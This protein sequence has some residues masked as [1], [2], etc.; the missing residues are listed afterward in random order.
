MQERGFTR[1]ERF[2]LKYYIDLDWVERITNFLKP[3]CG[4]DAYSERSPDGFYW[5]TNNY[6][7]NYQ[8]TFFRWSYDKIDG[9][10][11]MRIRTYG[12]NPKP[13]AP[14]FFEVKEKRRDT[15]IKTRGTIR[16]GNP[17]RLWNDTVA[18]LNESSGED[19]ANL[20][21]FLRLSLSYN[22]EPRYLT[23][24]K[25]K[26]WF[27][28]FEDYTRITVDTNMRWREERSYDHSVSDPSM[29]TSSDIPY[30]TAPG[31]NAVLELKC[32]RDA[33]PWWMLDLIRYLD[34]NRV[35]Y[36]KF[37][38]ASFLSQHKPAIRIP[39]FR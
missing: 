25:R 13:T 23:Q 21:H 19:R 22:V 35:G 4:L 30:F 38:S 17:E 18:V 1:L 33:V 31:T 27:G 16:G 10:I 32:E 9:R 20:E 37:G 15:V 11:D 12:E 6:L 28:L 39:A 3:W 29:M 5:I 2:E 24:Y 7:D 8:N 34:I 26:A 14:C 36:S